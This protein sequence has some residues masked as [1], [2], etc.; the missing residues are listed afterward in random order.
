MKR[1]FAILLVCYSLCFLNGC[2][3][4]G[5]IV[6]AIAGVAGSAAGGAVSSGLGG[7]AGAEVGGIVGGVVSNVVDQ[8]GNDVLSSESE[9]SSE[10]KK[11]ETESTVSL[12]GEDSN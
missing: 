8:K 5:V 9:R 12:L 11:G 3:F 4:V 1:T 7:S 10:D 6:Q 2:A